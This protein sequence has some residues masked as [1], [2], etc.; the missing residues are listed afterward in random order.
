[1]I[2][3]LRAAVGDFFLP[4]TYTSTSVTPVLDAGN[5]VLDDYNNPTYT[6]ATPVTGKPCRYIDEHAVSLREQGLTVTGTPVLHVAYDD[7]LS[8]GDSV[9]DVRDTENTVVFAGP[10]V[11]ETIV[12]VAGFGASVMKRAYLRKAEALG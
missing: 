4:H 7:T 1:M 12:P 11:V 6:S 8:E 2:S 3:D 9:S 10:A 5:P